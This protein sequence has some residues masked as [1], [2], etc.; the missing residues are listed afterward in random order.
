MR[1]TPPE[2]LRP[3]VAAASDRSGSGPRNILPNI[4]V[5]QEGLVRAIEMDLAAQVF[6][7]ASLSVVVLQ[8]DDLNRIAMTDAR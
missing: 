7:W 6:P 1:A 5:R 4:V 8:L 3:P 2:G